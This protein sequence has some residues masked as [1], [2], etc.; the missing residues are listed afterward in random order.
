MLS[1]TV[2]K[3]LRCI[4]KEE[5]RETA[6]FVEKV[7]KFFDCLNVTNYS[8]S[9]TS[10]KPFKM[11]YHCGDDFRMK[12][13]CL[14]NVVICAILSQWLKEFLE[15]LD[16]WEHEVEETDNVAIVKAK[17]ILSRE[18][19]VGIWITGMIL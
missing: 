3:G 18:T 9:I 13:S 10:L 19:L 8:K 1:E 5:A 12:V 2:A 4:F 17:M 15:W 16:D 11:P 7:D 6:V 14:M